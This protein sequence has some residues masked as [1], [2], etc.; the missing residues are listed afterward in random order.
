[1][2]SF[3]II[4]VVCAS[5][6]SLLVP[7]TVPASDF[8]VHGENGMY[9][10]MDCSDPSCIPVSQADVCA[11][12]CFFQAISQI[13]F[14]SAPLSGVFLLIVAVAFFLATI[15]QIELVWWSRFQYSHLHF[16]QCIVKR[17]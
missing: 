7:H 9:A 4:L 14:S 12:H 3:A 1:M 15:S 13:E 10:S 17:E 8:F 5:L 11:T 16:L 2:R 6:A